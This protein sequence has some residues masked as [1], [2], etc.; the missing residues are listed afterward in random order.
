MADVNF[1]TPMFNIGGIA[2]GL[3]T[4]AI[5][6][7]LLAV[8]R[9][10]QV[11]VQQQQ[12]VEEARQQALRDVNTRLLNLQTAVTGLRDVG[13]WGDTQSIDSSDPSKVSA[14]RTGG[15]A[16]GGYQIA[17]TKLARAAQMTQGTSATAATADGTL[18][19]KVGSGTAYDV[20]VTSGDTLQTV[21]DRINGTSGM[22]A[23]ASV[24]NSKLVLSGK[25]TGAANTIAVS[26]TS[27][28]DFGFAQTQSAQDAEYTL[29]NVSK[30]S[31]SN[32]IT[33]AMAGVTLTL[34]ATTAT[35]V[36]VN[37]GAPGPDSQ[38]VQGKVKAFVDQYNS[39]LDFIRGKLSEATVPN[40]TTD[41]D[42][43]KGLLKGDPALTGLLAAMRAAIADPVS[44]RPTTTQLLSQVGVSTGA[45]TGTGA[46]SKDAIAGKLTLDA[47][48]LSDQLANHF[49]DTK[50]LF[51]NLT[52]DYAT[53][54][55]AQRLGG[56]LDGWV[57]SDGILDARI[58]GEQSTI[59]SL[60]KRSADMD[61]RLAAREKALRAQFTAMEQALSQS[62]S[63]GS[64]LSSQLASLNAA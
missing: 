48:T 59:D 11:R 35:A 29:D 37:V 5:V 27:A 15:A 18:T 8:E 6:S 52:G 61:V 53:E 54:G 9:Q 16:A 45:T 19:I 13:T 39:T 41:A 46:L 40:A 55:L 43:A 58:D 12:R 25:V 1:S 62:Q 23:Y 17:V 44:G 7:Q 56:L 2:S 20:A 33:D 10:P 14:L 31:A 51:T 3:D 60:K 42:R 21:A 63:Q 50:A 38:A 4:N 34:K 24:V 32:V 30:T 49:T 26:G 47:T 22:Q 36:S 28:A 57:K 64:Y